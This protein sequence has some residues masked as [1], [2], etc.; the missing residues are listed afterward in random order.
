[1]N[2]TMIERQPSAPNRYGA[3]RPLHRVNFY[4]DAPNAENVRLIGDFNDWDLGANPLH[5][6]PDGRWMA[7]VELK[8]GHHRYLFVVDGRRCLDPRASGTV[9]G[10]GEEPMSLVAVS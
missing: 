2:T 3:P 10:R 6:T 4:C 8:H 5:R 1:M 9:R 7:S